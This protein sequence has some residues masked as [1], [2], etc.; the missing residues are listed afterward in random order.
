MPIQPDHPLLHYR[1]TEK[2]G[3]GGMGEVWK[4]LDTTLDR[5]VAIKLLPEMFA[6]DAERLARFQREAKLLAS[7]N[8]PNIAAVYG[9]HEAEGHRFLAME[10]VPGEDLGRRLQ[11]GALPLED[12]IQVATRIAAA[13]EAAHGQ[14]VIHRD[15]KPANVVLAPDGSVKVLDFGLAKTMEGAASGSGSG[16]GPDPSASPTVTSAGSVAGVILGTAAYM[17]PEQAKGRIL[18]RRS[19]IWSFGV[20]LFEMLTGTSP[21]RGETVSETLAEVLKGE[22]DW[23]SLPAATPPALLRLIERCLVRDPAWRLSDMGDA[24]IELRAAAEEEAAGVVAG[25]GVGAGAAAPSRSARTL[26]AVLG[27][28]AVLAVAT[29]T[30]LAL[31]PAPPPPQPISLEITLPPGHSIDARPAISPDGRTVAYHAVAGAGS[32]QL[33]IR[34]L[35]EFEP[36]LIGRAGGLGGSFFSPDGSEVGYHDRGSLW[37]VPVAGGTPTPLVDTPGMFG[38]T[39]ARDGSIVWAAGLNSGLFRLAL[40]SATPER[41]TQPD[42]SGEGYA[43]IFPQALPDGR[44]LYT[45][46]GAREEHNF[47]L[48]LKTR[49]STPVRGSRLTQQSVATYVPGHLMVGDRRTGLQIAPLDPDAAAVT[50]PARS[51][52]SGVFWYESIHLSSAA[53]SANGTLVY[54]PGDPSRRRLVWVDREGRVTPAIEAE[55]S[56]MFPELSPDGRRA[57][58]TVGPDVVVLDLERGSQTRLSALKGDKLCFK[59]LWMPDG[60][61]ILFAS[62]VSGRWDLYV[63]NADATGEDE[64]LVDWEPTTF[65]LSISRDGVVLMTTPGPETGLDLWSMKPGEEPRPYVA[66]PFEEDAARFS[67]DGTLVAYSSNESGRFEVYV[68]S[69]PPGGGRQVV[70]TAGGMAPAWSPDGSRLYYSHDGTIWEVRVT[71]SPALRFGKPVRL[72]SGDFDANNWIR[73]VVTKG[74][75]GDRFLMVLPLPESMPDRLRVV[76]GWGEQVGLFGG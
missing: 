35:S 55:Q 4:A 67:P 75:D 13:L 21:Y 39:W 9:L 25:A 61:R 28:V 10:F 29:A 15:L 72:F 11:R 43:H 54:A 31:Q 23:N 45:R 76:V 64:R 44:I 1:L 69:Y 3:Q 58:V 5:E 46:W 71:R 6:A 24:R 56:Y 22:P 19:D 57:V 42:S 68:Q 16:A 38:G 37:R 26:T 2:L 49:E 36:R 12:A 62:N 47:I 7:L 18:D 14:G 34:D 60:K 52:A 48:D 50:G 66:T 53:V 74:A 73:F 27:A 63:R 59:P 32:P 20:T 30:W 51:V 33:Y 40:G 17:S 65:P 70:S 8:H 41:L